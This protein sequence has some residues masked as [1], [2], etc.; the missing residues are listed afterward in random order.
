MH[1]R[2][3]TIKL[4]FDRISYLKY[5]ACIINNMSLHVTTKVKIITRQIAFMGPLVSFREAFQ[6]K[7]PYSKKPWR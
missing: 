7:G 5:K 3:V 4:Q 1:R 6:C 2:R